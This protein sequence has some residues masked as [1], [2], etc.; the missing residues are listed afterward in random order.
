LARHMNSTRLA[1]ERMAW[2]D[3]AA[4]AA[5]T[6]LGATGLSETTWTRGM[7]WPSQHTFWCAAGMGMLGDRRSRAG[8]LALMLVPLVLPRANRRA[9]RQIA[10]GLATG[11]LGA[12]CIG[13]FLSHQLE[14]TA[15]EVDDLVDE[16]TVTRAT[17]V[18][19]QVNSEIELTV[20]AATVERLRELQTLLATDRAA[21]AT[22]A[23]E[24]VDRLTAWFAEEQDLLGLVR[25]QT[26]A[27]ELAA[28]T[29]AAERLDRAVRLFDV[30]LRLIVL[31]N[32]ATEVRRC[33]RAFG[34]TFSESTVAV[35]GLAHFALA[36][37]L[38]AD[39]SARA[40]AVL[41]AADVAVNLTSCA[42]EPWAAD[43]SGRPQWAMGY[44]VGLAAAAG[45]TSAGTGPPPAAPWLMGAT[46]AAFELVR[47]DTSSSV[48]R[49]MRAL[50]EALMLVDVGMT[51]RQTSDLTIDQ[52]RSISARAAELTEARVLA[53]SARARRS[54]EHFLHDSALQVFLW[55]TKPDLGNEELADWVARE[56]H[57]LEDL[58][59]GRSPAPVTD[60]ERAVGDLLRGF[61]MFGVQTLLD[62]GPGV[63]EQDYGPAA[64]MCVVT[65]LNEALTNVLKHSDDRTPS[66]SLRVGDTLVC[67]VENELHTTEQPLPAR[68][69]GLGLRS[70]RERAGAAGG[71][72][73]TSEDDD[74]FTLELTL[75]VE[76][77]AAERAASD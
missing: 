9:L 69:A 63:F 72:V 65:V 6:M 8:R 50:D 4:G 13:M 1:D 70:V 42:L 68:G 44:S 36:L 40:K 73:T 5:T 3:A 14:R 16:T 12:G 21:A 18:R 60:L 35:L 48:V 17:A 20:V 66:V 29:D 26:S 39:G 31:L 19:Q 25:E 61:E 43:G 27:A 55:A 51:A 71:T 76:P 52:A 23:A 75:P 67:R 33:R 11:L 58:L 38:L 10:P 49:T 15:R 46:R 22:L 28:R 74:Q 47:A 53:E 64:A 54:H 37:A 62:A 41:S 57:A 7:A 45:V 77:A 32:M 56:L 2:A 30:A 24:E 34:A 59:D